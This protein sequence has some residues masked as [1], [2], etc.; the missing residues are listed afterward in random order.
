[1]IV[2][3]TDLLFFTVCCQSAIVWIESWPLIGRPL[4][5][6]PSL[7]T[8]WR[9]H[10]TAPLQDRPGP[11]QTGLFDSLFCQHV[12]VQISW[13][14]GPTV[15]VSPQGTRR[16]KT[17]STSCP[18]PPESTRPQHKDSDTQRTVMSERHWLRVQHNINTAPLPL[19][20][21]FTQIF[22][23]SPGFPL[24]IRLKSK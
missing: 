9:K 11:L 5:E 8:W 12:Q 20:E 24:K 17:S 2:T 7:N 13:W 18:P 1:M 10:N 14:D 19:K 23:L 21:Q 15:S 4:N 22:N 6:T 3:L 16:R